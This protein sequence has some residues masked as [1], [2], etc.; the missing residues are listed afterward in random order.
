MLNTERPNV[1][2]M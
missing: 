2:E 1:T